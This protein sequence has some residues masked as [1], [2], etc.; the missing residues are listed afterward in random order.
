MNVYP[1]SLTFLCN[2]P[3]STLMSNVDCIDINAVGI[4]DEHIISSPEYSYTRAWRH[5]STNSEPKLCA[6]HT[7]LQAYERPEMGFTE[8]YP[9][10]MMIPIPY[11]RFAS[12]ASIC[13]AIYTLP[14]LFAASKLHS[15]PCTLGQ[16]VQCILLRFQQKCSIITK[17][18]CCHYIKLRS[19]VAY[20]TSQKG[21]SM[22]ASCSVR[23]WTKTVIS[24]SVSQTDVSNVSSHGRK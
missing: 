9:C 22:T 20:I 6:P 19:I 5:M 18:K 17:T 4:P 1:K 11:H 2:C 16:H 12:T 8:S 21:R 7:Q 23:S 15:D 14:H 3:L 24:L 10:M 13:T